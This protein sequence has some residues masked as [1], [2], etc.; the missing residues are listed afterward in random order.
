MDDPSFTIHISNSDSS[1]L[2]G[3]NTPHSFRVEL[4]YPVRLPGLW[5]CSVEGIYANSTELGD[6]NAPTCLHAVLDFVRPSIA[7]GCE[8]R[9]GATFPYEG[10]TG[11]IFFTPSTEFSVKVDRKVI[12]TI[13]VDIMT[14]RLSPFDDL[15]GNTILIL[16]FRSVHTQMPTQWGTR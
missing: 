4:P 8:I 12:H 13:K 7:Y 1:S 11:N 10:K 3:E 5:V 2:Y 14:D 16:K 6:I 9:I 15:S